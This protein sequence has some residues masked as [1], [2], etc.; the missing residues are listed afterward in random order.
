MTIWCDG[1]G[2]TIGHSDDTPV[3]THIP[4]LEGSWSVGHTSGCTLITE[5]TTWAYKC[6]AM[7]WQT[8][9]ATA[10][11]I[12][13]APSWQARESPRPRLPVWP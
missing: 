8:G 9:G 2:R 1:Y 10:W 6:T 5:C 7:A 12:R 4:N 11:P 13:A 3:N